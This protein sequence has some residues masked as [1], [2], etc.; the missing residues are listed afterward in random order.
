MCCY[1]ICDP[2]M[3]LGLKSGLL[4]IQTLYYLSIS[5][6]FFF[7]SS[8]P[9]LISNYRW[10]LNNTRVRGAN[11]CAGENQWITLTPPNFTTAL[12]YLWGLVL[13]IPID[14]KTSYIKW[15]KEN[16]AYRTFSV[17][18]DSQPEIEILLLTVLVESTDAKPETM[19]HWLYI[20]WKKKS[21][22]WT[23]TV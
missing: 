23:S 5:V 21:Y 3:L 14:I 10:R 8:V 9:C 1:I 2:K 7:L 22:K 17:S 11:P 16:N 19:E 18:M 6:S 15:H 4:F 20:Y 13:G 12:W